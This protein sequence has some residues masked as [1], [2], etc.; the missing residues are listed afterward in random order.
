MGNEEEEEEVEPNENSRVDLAT[1]RRKN[2]AT[3]YPS[4]L[5]FLNRKYFLSDG[6][7]VN[8]VKKS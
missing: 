4:F 3:C 7:F 6:K 1:T 5:K 2:D 8:C